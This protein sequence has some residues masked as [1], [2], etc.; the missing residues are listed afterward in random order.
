[1]QRQPTHDN[2]SSAVIHVVNLPP[3]R[4][5]PVL[6]LSLFVRRTPVI[7]CVLVLQRR[8]S[9]VAGKIRNVLWSPATSEADPVTQKVQARLQWPN[10]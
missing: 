8:L 5:Q 6:S 2:F 4:C 10:G 9:I 7:Y 3:Y 1:M